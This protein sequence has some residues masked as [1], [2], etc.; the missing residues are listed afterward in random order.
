M[1][2][3]F[4]SLIGIIFGLGLLTLGADRLVVGA[5]ALAKRFG[6]SE[7]II[8]LTIV[9]IGTSMPELIVSLTASLE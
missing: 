3:V 7:A 8:G 5:V 6:L 2:A 1:L 9:A 4:I